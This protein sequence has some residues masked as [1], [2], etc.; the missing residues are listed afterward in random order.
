MHTYITLALTKKCS[1]AKGHTTSPVKLAGEEAYSIVA[2]NWIVS[3]VCMS[4]GFL[5]LLRDSLPYLPLS[6]YICIMYHKSL[7]F[8]C[9]TRWQMFNEDLPNVLSDILLEEHG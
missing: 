3:L 7:N 8:C 6:F 2:G 5:L 1:V 9:I 4:S